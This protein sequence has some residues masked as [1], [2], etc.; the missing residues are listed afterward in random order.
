M[1][2]LTWIIVVTV[3]QE[4]K[5]IRYYENRGITL[6]FAGRCAI[7]PRSAGGLNV[8]TIKG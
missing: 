1:C 3:I 2:A 8:G 4:V 6:R 7:K 5:N